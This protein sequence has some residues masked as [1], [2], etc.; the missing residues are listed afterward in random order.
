MRHTDRLSEAQ[1][2]TSKAELIEMQGPWNDVDQ[3]PGAIVQW[4]T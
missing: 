1:I 3:V 2:S 4:I